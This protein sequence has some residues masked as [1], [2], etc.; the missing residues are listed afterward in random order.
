MAKLTLKSERQIQTDILT[1]II[2]ELGLNDANAGSVLDI[3]SQAVAQEDFAQYVAMAQIA[4]LVNLDAI[5]GDDLD[6]KAFEYGLTR[7]QALKASGIIDILR[8]A[9][10]VKVSTTFFA[11]SPAPIVGN[12]QIDVNDASSL[13][14]GTSGTLILGRGTD[15][16]EEVTFAAAPIDFTN[17]WRFVTS[18]LTKN[19]AVEETVILKQGNDEVILAGT[20][21]RV[22]S[23]G[24][25]AEIIFRLNDDITLQA[26]EDKVSN[27]DVTAIK[28]GEEGNIPVKAIE[29]E[30]AF[31]TPPFSGARAQNTSKF[32]T[33]RNRQTDNELRDAIR[34]HVQS[35]SRG[36]KQAILNAI[37]GL[38]D[39]GSAKRVVSANVVLPQNTN[40]P[41]KIYIDDGTGFEPSFKSRGFENVLDES[42][43][44][45]TRLQLDIKPLVKAQVENNIEE[46][47][48]M[49][50]GTK[51]LIYNIGSESETVTFSGSDFLFPDTATAEEIVAAINDK[52]TLIE[53]RTSQSG[54]QIVITA[55]RDVNEDIQV[56]GGTSNSILG[57]PTDLKSTLFLYID[58]E[59]KSKDGETA[60]LD[61]GNQSPYNL[62]AIGAAPW[63][64]TVIVD[65]KSA[66]EQTVTFQALD[67][68]DPTAA[69][70]AEIIAVINDQLS[71]AEA[72]GVNNNTRVR[73]VSNTEL[74]TKSKLEITGG[75]IN[76]ATNGLNFSTTEKVGKNGDYTL[77]RE[78]GTIEI[79]SPLVA[80]QSVSA[81][82]LFTRARLRAG[83][84]EL[85][86]PSNGETLVIAVD[87][88][89]DQTITFD[90]TFAG[91]KTAQDT[92][93]FINAQLFGATAIVRQVGGQ[94]FI[95][96]NSNTYDQLIGSLEIKGTSTANGAFGFDLDSSVTNQ[97]PHK[98]TQLSGN[99]GPYEFSEADSL[100]MILDNDIVNNT[101]AVTMDYD[102]VVTLG[103]STTVFR[104]SAF[105]NIFQTDDE[106][107]DFYVAFTSGLNTESGT[108]A[109]VSDQAGDTWR[110]EFDALPTGLASYAAGDLIKVSDL[111]QSSNNG[112]FVITAV[113]TVGNGY[114]EVTN[115][116]GIAETLQSGT[117]LLSQRRQITD[118]V[119]LTGTM[120][121]GSAFSN[122]PVASDGLIVI[123]STI[124]NL[125]DFINNTKIT[126]FSLKGIVEGAE[127]NTKLQLSSK[128][129]GSDGYIQISGGKANALL[130]F[131]TEVFRGLQG[132][133]YYTG[134]LA[135]THKTIYG[136]D[137]DLVSFPGVGAA[138]ITFQVLAP[139]V[140]E[141]N[142]NVD[143][144]LTEG[145]SLASLENSIKS[146]ITGY[147]N[148]LGV[149][150]DVIIEEIRAA[151]IKINGVEDVVLNSPLTNIPAADNELIRTRD[152]LIIVG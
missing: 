66:N 143:V 131:D 114:V 1:K 20:S 23:T 8:P 116:S 40:E 77:N 146:A 68:Q 83:T 44:G 51:T 111:T 130:N 36:V 59:L 54:K 149:G 103:T 12:T 32:T 35:L 67:F 2:A 11:G 63:D 84:Q 4:R 120:T 29:G 106:L 10:F 86:S 48:D 25:S 38:V 49:S 126:S 151:V 87:G 134:L 150:E 78:L 142:I 53:A 69:T 37:V 80:N 6:N 115:V 122:T 52:A 139:T 85:Y 98:A 27:V 95:E 16:E 93:D 75:S 45:E 71:G 90:A 15:N 107:V 3:I 9:S 99:A 47:Y 109:T 61:S 141:L 128:K 64:L 102:G 57:F 30:G 7:R 97:R 55:K 129:E 81:A 104:A 121:V 14:I 147:I 152:S 127:N 60:V 91:G 105:A 76:D 42:T 125:V 26:G 17:Y 138:G 22:Q 136:D 33:G 82:S 145:V 113:S 124:N 43:G 117:A 65:G 100:V 19:H 31:P 88:G 58:D 70:V 140:K 94:N 21:V 39:S 110:L 92:A 50:G 73:L 96:I 28:A 112:Y 108:I 18:A 34:S 46:P 13:L 118:Y 41:V 119:A 137:Q 123:P 132:Y 144:T 133:N 5:T 79:Q 74:S 101:F 56:T 72:I 89:S 148:N 135:L 24:T 62:I